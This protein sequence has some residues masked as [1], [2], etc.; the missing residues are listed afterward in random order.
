MAGAQTPPLTI[1]IT[2]NQCRELAAD[3]VEAARR[4]DGGKTTA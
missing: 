4:L 1:V 3:L 2:A